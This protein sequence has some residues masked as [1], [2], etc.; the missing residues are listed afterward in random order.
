VQADPLPAYTRVFDIAQ[1]LDVKVVA[2]MSGFDGSRDW[3]GNLE[4]FKERFEPIC[5]QAQE[6][7][8][9]IALENWMALYGPPPQKPGNFGGGPAIWDALFEAVPSEALGLEFDP[10]HLYWQG[11]D[12]I[13]ALKEYQSKVFHVHAKDTEMLP[14]ERYRWGAYAAPFVSAFPAT[15]EST[16]RNLWRRWAKLATTAASPSNTKTQFIPATASTKACSAVTMFCSRSFTPAEFKGETHAHSR[17]IPTIR[18]RRLH[19]CPRRFF[20]P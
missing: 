2:S 1:A 6:R 13:R 20:A 8:L 16:G 9:K 14:E 7:G 12:H 4:L 19:S 5:A 3:K 11:I 15:A 17:T 18:P 10:S